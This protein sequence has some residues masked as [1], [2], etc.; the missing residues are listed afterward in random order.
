MRDE[1]RRLTL[2]ILDADNRAALAI[3]RSLGRRGHR[4]IIGHHRENS[5]AGS[6]RYN[7][8]TVL[9]PDPANSPQAFVSRVAALADEMKLDGIIPVSDITTLPLAEAKAQD[10]LPASLCLPAF[11]SLDLAADKAQTLTKAQELGIPVPRTHILD[12]PDAISLVPDAE[13]PFPAV[14]KPARSRVWVNDHWLY[15]KVNYATNRAELMRKLST[16]HPAQY[17]ILLQERIEGEGVGVFLSYQDGKCVSRFS[18]LRLREKPPSGGVSVLRESIPVDTEAGTHAE[19]LL[20]AI[21]WHGVAMV[22]FKR[23][24]RDGQLKL[25]EINGRFW[26]SLQLAI[27]AGVDFPDQVAR[28]LAGEH[29]SRV[30]DYATGVQTRWFWGDVDSMLAL[31]LKK[32]RDLNLPASHPGRIKTLV[33]FLLPWKPGMHYEV[34]RLKD[35]RPFAYESRCWLK[36][37]LGGEK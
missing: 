25:M 11:S 27:D 3:T 21:N 17:P 22:E 9:L 16:V 31:L 18:H 36:R 23:D 32:S 20:S 13:I 6:S 30:D 4:I 15:S 24:R 14:F 37:M 26:G 8:R 19:A 10:K 35:I 28:M 2:L 33:N 29:L 5:L 1:S 12:E 34:F 7:S